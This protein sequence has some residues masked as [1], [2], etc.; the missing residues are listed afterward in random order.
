MICSCGAKITRPVGSFSICGTCGKE[1]PKT[2]LPAKT[3]ETAGAS[4]GLGDTF[5]PNRGLRP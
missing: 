1:M 2:A 5:I 4:K 3:S